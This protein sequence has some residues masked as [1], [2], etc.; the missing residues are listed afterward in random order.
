MHGLENEAE[1]KDSVLR[2]AFAVYIHLW[3]QLLASSER[4]VTHSLL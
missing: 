3:Q 2:F 4:G 1:I